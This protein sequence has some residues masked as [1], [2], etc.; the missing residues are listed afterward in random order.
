MVLSDGA[1]FSLSGI[2]PV[3]KNL[4]IRDTK[5]VP[6]ES[7]VCF[8]IRGERTSRE[9]KEGFKWSTVSLRDRRET[10]S[11]TL[12]MGKEQPSSGKTLADDCNWDLREVIFSQKNFEKPSLN[13]TEGFEITVIGGLRAEFNRK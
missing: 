2:V 9:Q 3:L 1:C 13:D 6:T 12:H 4:F 5:H 11:N 10:R 8:K 7:K